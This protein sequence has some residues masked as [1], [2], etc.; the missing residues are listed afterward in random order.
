MISFSGKPFISIERLANLLQYEVCAFILFLILG[1]WLTYKLLLGKISKSRH[2][3]IRRQFKGLLAH[4]LVG[5]G[6]YLIFVLILKDPEP[7]LS[8]I[9]IAGLAGFFS[10]I[11]WAIVFIKT[12]RILVFE[13]LFLGHMK[14]GV[15]L[16]IVNLFT[17]V[18][19]GW[20]FGWIFTDL[21]MIKVGHLL[22]TSALLSVV[23]GLAL[24]DTLGNLFAGVSLQFD[25][26]YELGDWVEVFSGGT[27]W[28][29]QV[30]EITWRATLL[31]AVT[32]ETITIPNR[33]MAQSQVANFSV[34]SRPIIRGH[35]LRFP[36]GTNIEA[37]KKIVLGAVSKIEGVLQTPQPGIYVNEAHESWI[38][39]RLF[40]FISDYGRQWAL[41]DEVLQK[42]ISAL[43]SN[44]IELAHTEIVVHSSEPRKA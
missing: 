14:E 33:I 39:T 44:G 26:P 21:F 18:L 17:L 37:A 30:H 35:V 24:Q 15:P 10:L 23:V 16:L 9:R 31:V 1:A 13:Y 3:S 7:S 29:G 6:F 25:K 11:A 40:Y 20:L 38:N 4:L 19:S 32:E 27:K 22:A 8:R 41:G 36:Y 43:E 12:A 5:S 42:L 28:V 34:R 2:D